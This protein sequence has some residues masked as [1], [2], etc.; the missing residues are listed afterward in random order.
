MTQQTP[1]G[2]GDQTP[3]VTPPEGTGKTSTGE[4]SGLNPDQW[5]TEKQSLLKEKED[6]QKKFSDSSKGALALLDENKFL[7]AKLDEA[8]SQSLPDEEFS[9]RVPNWEYMT[10]G[11]KEATKRAILL[12]KQ[13]ASQ[14]VILNK[15][16]E[17]KAWEADFSKTLKAYPS[18]KDMQDEFK[19]YAYQNTDVK[20]LD[21]LAKAFLSDKQP[22][23]PAKPRLGL[24]K[25]VSGTKPIKGSGTYTTEEKKQLRTTDPKRYRELIKEGKIT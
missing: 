7:K 4:G 24:E 21:I 6:W 16:T 17:E 14:G 25:P 20:N 8:S 13:I 11:E 18:L 22:S 12:E 19:E 3:P 2:A 9:K 10:D 15:L 23:E 1:E 5:E